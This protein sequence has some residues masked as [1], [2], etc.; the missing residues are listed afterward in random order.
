MS[1]RFTR[2]LNSR[3][4]CGRWVVLWSTITVASPNWWRTGPVTGPVLLMRRDAT[5][6]KRRLLGDERLHGHLGA[7]VGAVDG[8][9]HVFLAHLPIVGEHAMLHDVEHD[10]LVKIRPFA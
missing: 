3:V 8:V 5:S 2:K 7:R 9:E 1:A 10:R 6:E 4:P